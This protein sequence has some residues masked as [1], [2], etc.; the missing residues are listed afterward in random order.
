[1]AAVATLPHRYVSE[2]KPHAL[3]LNALLLLIFW[4][5]LFF[6]LVFPYQLFPN[7]PGYALSFDTLYLLENWALIL[8]LGF[9]SLRA[10]APWR[11]IYLHLLSAS[12]LYALSSVVANLAIDAEGYA[13][14]KLYGVGLTAAVCWFVWIPLR[15][16]QLAGSKLREARTDSG[17]RSPASSWAMVAVVLISVPIV[18]EVLRKAEA[19]DVR[20]FRMLVAVGAIV[21]LA[22]AAFLKE[23]FAKSDL[24]AHLGSANDRLRLAMASGKAVGWEWDVRTSEVSWFG[25]LKTNFGIDS[26]TQHRQRAAHFF[27]RY[28]HPHDREQ[29]VAAVTDARSN[30]KLYEGEFRI[31]WPDGTLRWVSARGEFQYSSKGEPA[32]MLGMAFDITERKQLQSELVESQ[33]RILAIVASAM[34]AII[35]VD[36]AQT[37][38][39]FNPAAERMFDCPGGD[40]IGS[41]IER[42]IPPRFRAQ[43]STYIRHFGETGS[44]SRVMGT[45]GTLWALRA[46]GKEFPIE[47]SISHSNISGQLFSTV[48]I[49]DVTEQKRTEQALRKSEERFRLFMDHSP[50]VAWMKDEERHYI[51]MSESYLKQLEVRLED[52]LGKTDFEVY[53]CAIAEEL[54]KNDQAAL[55]L[56][57]PIEVTEEAVG[58]H[59]EPRIW[60]AYKFPFQDASGQV[61]VGGIGIDITEQKKSEETLHDL[62]GR[63]ISAQEEERAR[64]AREL[65]DDFSQ[66]LALLGIELGQLWKKLSQNEAEDRRCV[67]KMLKETKELSTDLH[68]L[69]HELHSSK[70]EYVGLGPALAGLC[71]EF[72]LKYE[73]EVR[74]AEIGKSL[75]VPKDA[76][77]CLFR[78]AQ[79]ALANVAKHSRANSAQVELATNGNGV[80][81]R[82]SDS[83]RGF[84]PSVQKL[85]AGIGLIGM[86]ERL[87]LVGGRLLVMSQPN[88]GTEI[89]A[90]VPLVTAED[91]TQVKSQVAGG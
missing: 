16:R 56:G 84:D 61:F 3:M 14:G 77:L 22:S 87:R 32:R 47:A 44:N 33:D 12:T 48:I 36:D 90:E 71:K 42:F 78:V 41:S 10:P 91:A 23:Y 21:C 53:P 81:L 52:R 43:H 5:F 8:A 46:D 38:V 85:D 70:L 60:L 59:G 24:A 45:L 62:T 26:E 9:L 76:A 79:E 4:S 58:P 88:S 37:I 34:D 72:G 35:G 51:Y 1:M 74:F 6:Y 54:R 89:V 73:I 50:A 55:D 19:T 7:A 69:S 18:W 75:S 17:Q 11:S 67:Q 40:A 68:T 27:N 63:L 25:D 82:I 39:L 28:V 86:S 66:R 49:R 83:G 80:T 30:H 2:R 57:H 29:V 20:R 15:A 64:I 31:A 65:H 13:N